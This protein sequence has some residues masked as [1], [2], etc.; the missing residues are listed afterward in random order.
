LAGGEALRPPCPAQVEAAPTP[1][2]ELEVSWVRRSRHGWAWLDDMDAPLG[3]ARELYRVALEGAGGIIE[4]ETSAT[5]L[6][7]DADQLAIVGTGIATLSI[8][9]LG[10]LAASR[11][12]TMTINLI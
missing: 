10:D 4:V 1:A 2:G 6:N 7:F 5:A 3:E 9:Q 12:A 11:A 8:R